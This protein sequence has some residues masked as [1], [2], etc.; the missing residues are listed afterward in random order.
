MVIVILLGQRLGSDHAK[1]LSAERAQTQN[2]TQDD[3]GQDERA[4]K[5]SIFWGTIVLRI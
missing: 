2:A 4:V 3:K 5:D 1:D